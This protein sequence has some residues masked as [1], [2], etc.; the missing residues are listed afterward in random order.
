MTDWMVRSQDGRLPPQLPLA[1]NGKIEHLGVYAAPIRF[2]MPSIYHHS[3]SIL[4]STWYWSVSSCDIPA[5]YHMILT[6]LSPAHFKLVGR[7]RTEWK[8][9][10]RLMWNSQNFTNIKK[11]CSCRT[12]DVKFNMFFVLDSTSSCHPNVFLNAADRLLLV[13]LERW[14][15]L[16]L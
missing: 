11:L 14:V 6:W 13:W 1:F 7:S 15:K 16:S 3:S 5:E 4:A 10:K 9:Q 8:R 12:P 2:C